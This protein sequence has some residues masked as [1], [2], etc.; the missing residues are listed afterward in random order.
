MKDHINIDVQAN[1]HAYNEIAYP[2]KTPIDTVQ[3]DN[4][5]IHN[6]NK[7]KSVKRQT[8]V[9]AEGDITD[10]EWLQEDVIEGRGVSSIVVIQVLEHFEDWKA[11][12]LLK[13]WVDLLVKGGDIVISV[14]DI[15]GITKNIAMAWMDYD[16]D[17]LDFLY[18]HI[19]GSHRDVYSAH[20][21]A[22]DVSKLSEFLYCAGITR[23]YPQQNFHAYP[24]IILKGTKG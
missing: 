5:Y 10:I 20:K 12:Q 24:A 4:Y 3:L 17:E 22:Y 16:R 1:E 18:R 14:P 9:D 19:Y 23:I 6:H 2:S 8:V 21:S 11:K 13:D 7:D 15:I